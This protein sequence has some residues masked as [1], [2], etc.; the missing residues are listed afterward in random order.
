MNTDIMFELVIAF[1]LIG[2][3]SAFGFYFL[4]KHLKKKGQKP[5]G[6]VKVATI[7]TSVV[8]GM[9]GFVMLVIPVSKPLS[10]WV[11][12]LIGVIMILIFWVIEHLLWDMANGNNTINW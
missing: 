4:G 1:N 11:V 3:G 8:T 7:T 9:I 6:I 12:V 2:L 5:K 10:I